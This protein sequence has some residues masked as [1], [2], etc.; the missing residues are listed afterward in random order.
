MLEVLRIFPKD[1]TKDM[2]DLL[3]EEVMKAEL[4]KT[5]FS[6]KWSKINGMVDLSVEFYTSFFEFL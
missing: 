1:I 3:E 5:L 4:E 6:M 2:N